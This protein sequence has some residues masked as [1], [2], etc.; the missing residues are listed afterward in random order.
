MSEFPMHIQYNKVNNQDEVMKHLKR[1]EDG[2]YM[3]KVTKGKK[4]SHPQNAYYW[5]VLLDYV[6]HGLMDVGYREAKDNE[7]VH[8]MMKAM[9]LK[10]KIVN[11]FSGEEITIAGST[12]KLTTLEFSG[13]IEEIVQWA[14]EYLSISIPMPNQSMNI[15]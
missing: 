5:G 13:F 14:A 1:L 4:R 6:R 3:V 8:E 2:F 7:T 11:E 9:F 15:Y 10:N 12:A